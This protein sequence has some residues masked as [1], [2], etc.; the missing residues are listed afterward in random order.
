MVTNAETAMGQS[1]QQDLQSGMAG[2]FDATALHNRVYESLGQDLQLATLLDAAAHTHEAHE[3][4]EDDLAE[5]T[6]LDDLANAAGMISH[7]AEQR[8][9]EIV[10]EACQTII[11]DGDQWVAEGHWDRDQID[12][13]QDEAEDWLRHNTNV[14]SRLGLLGGDD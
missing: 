8:A 2:E 7:V 3:Y 9:R 12:A 6:R 10:A 1:R 11:D 4:R 5:P 13:A 14:T